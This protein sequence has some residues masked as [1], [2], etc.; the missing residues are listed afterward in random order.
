MLL[1]WAMHPSVNTSKKVSKQQSLLNRFP[2]VCAN[3]GSFNGQVRVYDSTYQKR[4]THCV[5]FPIPF[6]PNRWREAES[7]KNVTDCNGMTTPMV[8]VSDG[9]SRSTTTMVGLARA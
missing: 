6:S 3:I 9:Q 1:I 7:D 4:S 5:T 2:I 8:R